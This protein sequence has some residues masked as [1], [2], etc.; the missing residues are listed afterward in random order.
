[1]DRK[2]PLEIVGTTQEDNRKWW[3]ENPMTYLNWGDTPTEFSEDDLQFY[4]KI[5]SIFLRHRNIFHTLVRIRNPSAAS[6]TLKHL[7]ESGS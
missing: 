7:M 4:R 6:S 3:E 5:D 2:N 1:M